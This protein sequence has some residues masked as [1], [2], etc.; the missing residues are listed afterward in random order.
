M[1][2]NIEQ[3]SFCDMVPTCFNY[4]RCH[5]SNDSQTS[6]YNHSSSKK[7]EN[8]LGLIKCLKFMKLVTGTSDMNAFRRVLASVFKQCLNAVLFP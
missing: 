7:Q 4:G 6:V 1:F 5:Y 3:I 2:V 8:P